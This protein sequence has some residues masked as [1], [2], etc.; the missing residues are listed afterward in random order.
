MP[1]IKDGVPF[2]IAIVTAQEA[3]PGVVVVELGSTPEDS[4]DPNSD[5]ITWV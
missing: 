5:E 1:L 2:H 3:V 4:V